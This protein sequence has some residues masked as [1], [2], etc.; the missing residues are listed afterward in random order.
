MGFTVV[1]PPG[2]VRHKAM[3][4][5]MYTH[6]VLLLPFSVC[7][8]AAGTLHYMHSIRTPA[9]CT[10]QESLGLLPPFSAEITLTSVSR[11]HPLTVIHPLK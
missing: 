7:T 10:V 9:E 2:I 4:L 1:D 6:V 11:V 3:L 5:K 8:H